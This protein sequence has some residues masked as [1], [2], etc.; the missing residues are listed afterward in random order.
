[1]AERDNHDLTIRQ[2]LTISYH[3]FFDVYVRA[4][5]LFLDPRYRP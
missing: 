4:L 1:M 3:S 2:L 5:F